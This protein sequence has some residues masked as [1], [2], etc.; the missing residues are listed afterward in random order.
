MSTGTETTR[1]RMFGPKYASAAVAGLLAGL[2]FGL[3]IQ[4]VLERMT[5]IGALYTL[6]DPSVSVG[7][8]AHLVHSAVF[9]LVYAAVTRLGPLPAYADAAP[10]GVLTGAAFGFALWFVNI[11]F[12][13]PVWLNAVGF[14]T[15]PVPYHA[16]AV[17]P[18]AGHLVWGGLLGGLFPLLVALRR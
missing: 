2:V 8:I 10:T 14:Q 15:L 9:A 13:W 17:R 5:A 3:L 11:G 1:P 7:W 16:Q 18:L 12:V 6:G 4:F